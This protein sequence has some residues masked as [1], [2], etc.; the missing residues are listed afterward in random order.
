VE[1]QHLVS[2]LKLVDTLREQALL[3]NLLEASKP[4][5]P[6]ECRHLHYLLATPFRYGA[7]YPSGSRFRR[8]GFTPGVYYGSE[9]VATAVAELSF[10]RLLFF[11]DSPATPSPVNALELTAF[12]IRYATEMAIDLTEPPLSRDR[13]AWLDPTDYQATQ[14]LAENARIV[15]IEVIR[16]ESARLPQQINVA[17]LTCRAFAVTRPTSRQIWRL[18]V[19]AGGA[20]A[21]CEY[22]EMRLEFPREAFPSDPRIARDA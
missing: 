7:P 19:G 4:V 17:L 8:A 9:K 10:H 2:T 16:S 5:V 22:P 11:V 1:G 20:R 12:S 21:I 15:G 13:Q 14:R 6:F 18:D 3:E